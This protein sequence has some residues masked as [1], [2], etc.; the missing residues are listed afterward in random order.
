M[1]WTAAELLLTLYLTAGDAVGSSQ[2][3]SLTDVF[4]LAPS[5]PLTTGTANQSVLEEGDECVPETPEK[6]ME[7]VERAEAQSTTSATIV[8]SRCLDTQ[9]LE[10][11]RARRGSRKKTV[12]KVKTLSPH[13]SSAS[14][15]TCAQAPHALVSPNDSLSHAHGT[16]VGNSE[17]PRTQNGKVQ[18]EIARNVHP[19]S[20]LDPTSDDKSTLRETMVREEETAENPGEVL[21]GGFEG[22]RDGQKEGEEKEVGEDEVVDYKEVLRTWQT[23]SSHNVM[24]FKKRLLERFPHLSP[25]LR[26]SSGLNVLVDGSGLL[27]YK[28]FVSDATGLPEIELLNQEEWTRAARLLQARPRL[29]KLGVH[30]SQVERLYVLCPHLYACVHASFK[31]ACIL[32]LPSLP[33]SNVECTRSA[34]CS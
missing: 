8:S 25:S 24:N 3:L 14:L 11:V 34:A 5:S 19:A 32:Y 28:V 15:R 9:M 23:T 18:T 30:Y 33:R 4:H 21:N 26:I 31:D 27:K 10:G 7:H 22:E 17:I 16:E 6:N 29:R 1:N 2:W 13:V 12:A 20:P